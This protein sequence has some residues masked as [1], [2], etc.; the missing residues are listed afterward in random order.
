MYVDMLKMCSLFFKA[1]DMTLALYCRLAE[2][3]SGIEMDGAAPS[4]R[5]REQ[6]A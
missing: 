3:F 6:L 1:L 5:K 4:S 2:L